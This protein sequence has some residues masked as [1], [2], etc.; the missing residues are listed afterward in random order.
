MATSNVNET[1]ENTVNIDDKVSSFG[2]KLGNGIGA[3]SDLA[4]IFNHVVTSRD[5]TPI[6]GAI[7]KA[8]AKKD[9]QAEKN[10]RLTLGAIY[11]DA[12]IITP[13]G[14]SMIIKI[15][16]IKADAKALE[17]L[18]KLV[19]DSVSIRGSKWANDIRGNVVTTK[20][21]ALTTDDYKKKAIA[22]VKA[23]YSGTALAAAISEVIKENA[24]KKLST[25]KKA[26]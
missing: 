15:K 22:L 10:I 16:G 11:K 14:K 5:T 6:V 25:K 24:A 3:G 12:E 2:R 18:T 8:K 7:N 26:A 17:R 9:S 21:T 13:K 23:G 20:P 1:I 19:T 4:E